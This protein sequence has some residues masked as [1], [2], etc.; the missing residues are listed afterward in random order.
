MVWA[1]E[2]LVRPRFS[3]T[4]VG[5]DGQRLIKVEVIDDETEMFA[6]VRPLHTNKPKRQVISVFANVNAPYFCR[7]R[8]PRPK[9][10]PAEI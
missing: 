8:D 5:G 1:L 3:A 7:R 10:I 4:C 2:T 9:L 6:T